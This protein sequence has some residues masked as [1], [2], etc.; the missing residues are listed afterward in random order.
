MAILVLQASFTLRR[1]A[2]TKIRFGF[3]LIVINLDFRRNAKKCEA[4][5][6]QTVDQLKGLHVHLRSKHDIDLLKKK[7]T[8]NE[9]ETTNS[10]TGGSTDASMQQCQQPAKKIKISSY[11]IT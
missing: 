9:T 8:N 1:K 3:T 7:L 10:S 5:S 2:M 6:R 11:F 4:K